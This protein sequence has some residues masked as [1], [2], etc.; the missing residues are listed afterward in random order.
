MP[1]AHCTGSK[2][3]FSPFQKVIVQNKCDVYFSICCD[4][5]HG[6]LHTATTATSMTQLQQFPL[7]THQIIDTYDVSKTAYIIA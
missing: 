5:R 3:L 2:S 6:Y 1:T 4:M 7:S